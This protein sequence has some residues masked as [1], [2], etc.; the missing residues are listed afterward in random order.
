MV[1]TWQ[2]LV[3]LKE[4]VQYCS[5]LHANQNI[6]IF[7]KILK[8][9]F[10]FY[11]DCAVLENCK[12]GRHWTI[13]VYTGQYRVML[14]NIRQYLTILGSTWQYSAIFEYSK[15]IKT[16][17]RKSAEIA[18]WTILGN[19]GQYFTILNNIAKYCTILDN[20]EQYLK[21]SYHIVAY[22]AISEVISC[23]RGKVM[24]FKTFPFHNFSHGRVLEEL[25]LLKTI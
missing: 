22:L 15:N 9:F 3:V 10:S 11:E 4:F 14:V 12:M 17:R 2:Y 13:L 1:N 16:R 23:H 20:I 24:L 6:Q 7:L 8:T 25:S 19:T 21:I 18:A 5:I